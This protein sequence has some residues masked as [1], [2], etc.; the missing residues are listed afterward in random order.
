MSPS[1]DVFIDLRAY[2]RILLQHCYVQ[3]KGSLILKQA[4]PL[5]SFKTVIEPP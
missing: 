4:P 2:R 1:I 5:S 3:D